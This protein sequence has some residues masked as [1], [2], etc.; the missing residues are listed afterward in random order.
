MEEPKAFEQTLTNFMND[1]ASGDAVRHLADAGLT[2]TEI[3]KRLAFPTK[4]KLVAEMVW[5]HYLDTGVIRLTKPEEGG[6]GKTR[7]VR[8]VQEQGP[9]GRT[10]LRQ[11]VEEIDAPA[12]SYTEVNFGYRLYADREGFLRKLQQLEEDDRDYILDLPWPLTKVWHVEND[13]VRRIR[14]H[15]TTEKDSVI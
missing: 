7:K 1:F 10:S 2:V 5:K 4:K 14:E 15:L 6:K 3:T 9:Y 11:V 13:R 8:Y 12:Y